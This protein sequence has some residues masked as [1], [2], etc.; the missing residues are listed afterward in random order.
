MC[1]ECL[2]HLLEAG[3]WQAA[4]DLLCGELAAP[5]FLENKEETSAELVRA[6]RIL[7]EHA[8]SLIGYAEGAGIYATHLVLRRAFHAILSSTHRRTDDG[9]FVSHSQLVLDTFADRFAACE[10]HSRGLGLAQARWG[11]RG[12]EVDPHTSKKERTNGVRRQEAFA[13]MATELAGWVLSD[14]AE[15]W[16]EE[17]P[18]VQQTL[19]AATVPAQSQ[20]HTAWN[21]RLAASALAQELERDYAGSSARPT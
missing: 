20:L 17:P 9:D 6:L 18:S 2:I 5:W 16:E 10:E 13:A 19:L 14:S 3:D 7:E 4:H 11:S 1:A 8:G 12:V 21:V 15:G